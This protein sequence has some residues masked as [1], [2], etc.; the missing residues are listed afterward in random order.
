M[1][2]NKLII[3]MDQPDL[4][5]KTTVE[6]WKTPKGKIYWDER[7]ARY[8]SCTHVSCEKC[9]QPSAKPYLICPTCDEKNNK[10]K[11][12]ALPSRE[13]DGKTPLYSNAFD[14]YFF[15]E[16]ALI[17]FIHENNIKFITDIAEMHLVF[18]EPEY[19][20]TIDT[21][22]WDLHEDYE[23]PKAVVDAMA[24]LNTAIA[25]AP[26]HCWY[27]GKIAAIVEMKL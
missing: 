5:T 23:I 1:I 13:W 24:A 26:P 16:D 10:E 21:E 18:A 2:E 4:V 9:G 17:D 22:N 15:S 11:Y 25:V 14:E 19:L 27:P 8:E 6:A 20:Q 7:S 3:M 12:A